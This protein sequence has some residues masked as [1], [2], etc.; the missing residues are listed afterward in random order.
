MAREDNW[1][2]YSNHKYQNKNHFIVIESNS[3][4]FHTYNAC[5]VDQERFNG[6]TKRYSHECLNI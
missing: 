2:Y 4:N 3:P 1:G 6:R 5:L